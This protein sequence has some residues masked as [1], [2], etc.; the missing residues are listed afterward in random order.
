VLVSPFWQ[1]LCSVLLC[2]SDFF[3]LFLV[4][5]P[6]MQKKQFAADAS[7][8]WTLCRYQALP[9]SIGSSG[10]IGSISIT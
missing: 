2:G 1:W 9:A 7:W 4:Y 10:G 6:K 8:R 3:F 5:F